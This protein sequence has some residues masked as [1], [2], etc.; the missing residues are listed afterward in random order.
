MAPCLPLRAVPD[1][2]AAHSTK[3][4]RNA[5]LWDFDRPNG[6]AQHV[7]VLVGK[8]RGSVLLL[9]P[10]LARYGSARLAPPGGDFPARRTIATHLQ[11]L[12][13]MGATALDEPGHALEARGVRRTPPALFPLLWGPR[14]EIF[15]RRAGACT[16]EDAAKQ[17]CTAAWNGTNDV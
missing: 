3:R 12:H 10:L 14:K 6:S 2:R 16:S 17:V 13:A 8:L 1:A 11:A 9:G 15:I 4:R 7:L 5:V